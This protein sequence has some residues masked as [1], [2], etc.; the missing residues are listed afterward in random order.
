MIDDFCVSRE[1]LW[2]T[3]GAQLIENIKHPAKEKCAAQ[4]LV[5]CG[6]HDHSKRTF[7]MQQDLSIA[8]EWFVG[9]IA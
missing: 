6:A 4:I 2:S 7:L 9:G 5:V 8:S 3:V 1:D